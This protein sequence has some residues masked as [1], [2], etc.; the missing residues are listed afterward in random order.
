[1][2]RVPKP[3]PSGWGHRANPAESSWKW[4]GNKELQEA[5]RGEIGMGPLEIP[6]EFQVAW[7]NE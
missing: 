3:E 5:E 6:W 7:H 1:M 4:A 2:Q